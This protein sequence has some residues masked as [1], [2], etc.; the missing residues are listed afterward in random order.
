MPNAECCRRYASDWQFSGNI[1]MRSIAMPV[2]VRGAQASGLIAELIV[3]PATIPTAS[4]QTD[5]EI[6]ENRPG[7]NSFGSAASNAP[8]NAASYQV[9]S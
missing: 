4:V 3:I 7:T 1:P 8:S 2:A 5:H 9:R 6:P